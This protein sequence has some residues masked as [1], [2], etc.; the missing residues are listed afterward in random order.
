MTYEDAR[1]YIKFTDTLG[2]VLGLENIK[3]LLKRLGNPQDKVR[4]VHIAGTNGKGSI[5]AFL[6][7][8]LEDAGYV[9]GRYISPTIFTYLERFQINGTYMSEDI[10]AVYLE[11]V[12]KA[13]D[14]MVAEGL[15]RPTSFETETAIAFCYFCDM[16]V[17][18]LLL[19]TGM[20]GLLDAT[21]VC[22]KPVCTIIA[23][24][25]MDHTRFLG[26]TIEEI[27][28]QKLGI[29]KTDVPCVS[30]PLDSK[31]L[32][33]WIEKCE[34]N[35]ITKSS[36]LVDA[37]DVDIRY[38][39][40]EGSEFSYKGREYR[41]SVP[42]I[43]QIYNSIVAVEAASVLK[44]SGY[45]LKK[46]NVERGLVATKWKGRFQRLMDSPVV[47]VDG[48]HNPGGWAALRKN[49]DT[50]FAGKKLIYIC[51]VFKDKDYMKMLEIMMP[52]A[53]AFIAVEP[54]NPRALSNTE[55]A[56]QACRYIDS[57]YKDSVY[58]QDDVDD[59]VEQAVNMA[60]HTEDSVVVIFG[61]L[62]FIGPI[63]E[64]AERNAYANDKQ[65]FPMRPPMRRV[66]NIL[67]NDLYIYLMARIKD[68]ERDRI[69]CC[70]G[71]DHC[72][73][74]ARIAYMIGKDENINIEREL[75]Y[76]AALL[77]DVGRADPDDTGVSHH[78]LSVRYAEDI[79]RQSGFDAEETELI[80]DAI[81]SHNTDG[82]GRDGLAY[83][84]Y[85]ADKLS[86][87]CFDCAA[88]GE[89]YWPDSER[90]KGIIY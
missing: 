45:E 57:R 61:S 40:L 32:P 5:C 10:F 7:G 47:Y 69:F 88:A 52:G 50:Y 77:H 26:D 67:H 78:I 14:A 76:A 43:Y 87:N 48:A 70:H 13:A 71:L 49:I 22:T 27:Y 20:G 4:V 83:I 63:I 58:I 30:Y 33:Q 54:D 24:I 2:S 89:C 16:D 34:E 56:R 86:R 46:V 62:S 38:S 44:D 17:D 3:E 64:K 85:K 80:C 79:L 59:A 29:L 51:G 35:H 12:K 60:R 19:E 53:A 82:A 68:K 41:L 81:G 15:S 37:A 25:S 90:N 74:V 28:D 73:D 39:G 84:L 8:I 9:V 36:I 1:E 31:L 55:L 75:L 72:L 18:V 6:D 11:Q 65:S 42:G 66:D 23:S 21:N